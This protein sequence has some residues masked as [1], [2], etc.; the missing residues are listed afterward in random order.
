MK[1][2]KRRLKFQY[3]IILIALIVLP[4]VFTP[5]TYSKYA[6]TK[7]KHLTINAVQPTYTV[8]FHANGGSGSMDDQDFV[9]KTAQNLRTNTF[10]KSGSVFEEWTTNSDGTGDHYSDHQSVINLTTV[11]NGVIHLYAQWT[12]YVAR[13]GSDY[14]TSL[15]DAVAVAN[16]SSSQTTII[17]L[18]NT[19]EKIQIN[20]GKNVILDL[21]GKTLSWGNGVNVQDTYNDNTIKNYGTLEVRNGKVINKAATNGGIN[22]YANATITLDNVDVEVQ[23]G[24]NRQA[25]YN[26]GTATITGGSTLK[27]IATGRCAVT[28]RYATSTMYVVDATIESTGNCGLNNEGTLYIG[29]QGGTPSKTNPTIRGKDYGV[30]SDVNFAFYDGI[31]EGRTDPVSDDTKITVYEAGYDFIE[32][33]ISINNITYHAL[34]LGQKITITFDPNQGTVSELS[35]DIEMGGEI[36]PLPTPTRQDYTFDGWF[37]A[38]S[39]GTQI[40]QSTTFNS[41]TT[42]YAQWTEI[43]ISYTLTFDTM[44]GNAMPALTNQPANTIIDLTQ[45][46]PTRSGYDFEGWYDDNI[47]SNKITSVT[48]TGDTTVFANWTLQLFDARIGSTNYTTLAD[49]WTDAMASSTPSTIVLLRDCST[50]SAYSVSSSKNVTVDL[51]GHSIENVDGTIFEILNGGTFELTDSASGGM[52]SGGIINSSNKQ[53]PVIVNKTGGNVTISGGTVRS[54]KSQVIDNSGTMNIT[55]GTVTF[56]ASV[57]QGLINNNAGATMNISGGTINNPYAIQKGQAVYNLGTLNISG[58]AVLISKTKERSVVQNAGTGSIMNISGGTISSTYTN[59]NTGAVGNGAGNTARIT[60][61]TITSAS[62]N[63]NSGAVTNAGT[64]YVGSKDGS[65]DITTPVLQGEKYGVNNTNVFN[66]YDGI[67]KGAT[68]SR[69]GTITDIENNSQLTTGT[70]GNYNTEYLVATRSLTNSLLPE[71]EPLEIDGMNMLEV[72]DELINND[73]TNEINNNEVVTPGEEVREEV[74]VPNNEEIITTD[75]TTNTKEVTPTEIVD[76]QVDPNTVGGEVVIVTPNEVNT[77]SGEIV[78][79]NPTEE[80]T[81]PEEPSAEI[82][83][84]IPIEDISSPIEVEPTEEI[85]SPIEVEPTEVINSPLIGEITEENLPSVEEVVEQTTQEE[86]KPAEVFEEIVNNTEVA[87]EPKEDKQSTKEEKEETNDNKEETPPKKEEEEPPNKEVEEIPS[88][89]NVNN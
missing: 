51:N 84:D 46:T 9:Y 58:D 63:A 67:L 59:C 16:A 49:A 8:K 69:N 4:F 37:D 65:I 72:N 6:E 62:T 14:Y 76:N 56:Y 34:Y 48:L 88:D 70:D 31:L 7:T 27:S 60:G 78:G 29:T 35:R 19:T 26:E 57:N 74:I 85:S 53:V 41:S 11:N 86:I 2:R 73:L 12:P 44:G 89:L 81:D 71:E 52:I 25:L 80:P 10:T 61:G 15:A 39:G 55:G 3:K 13:I 68:A 1:R 21:N 47:Y 30:T 40:I 66:F 79:T 17:L 23:T 87:V 54:N 24:G 77:E 22:N 32:K 5:T 42:I 18:I 43:P 33:D 64:L 38:S 28:N 82:P 20:S 83:G 75:D 45:Y 50:S 36:G